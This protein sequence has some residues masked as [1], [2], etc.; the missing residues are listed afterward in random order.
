M[1]CTVSPHDTKRRV[2]DMKIE[3]IET[4]RIA[5]FPNLLWVEVTTDEGVK[6]LGETFFGPRAVEAYLHETA[7]PILLGRD[8]LAIDA[9][10]R[11]L[12]GYIGFGAAGAE[13]RGAS[14]IDI[15]LWDIFG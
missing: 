12:N 8:P 5:E 13:V 3:K 14:A 10:A 6:G 7:A 2:S 11:A 15:A 4:I 9:N 1:R